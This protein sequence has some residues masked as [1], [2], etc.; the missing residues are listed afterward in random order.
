M[1]SSSVLT[2]LLTATAVVPFL[3]VSASP[4]AA[5][6]RS[7][8]L[9]TNVVESQFD[10]LNVGDVIAIR[11]SQ[12]VRKWG[13]S[14]DDNATQFD[15]V[16][17]ERS[18]AAR[19]GTVRV[20][21]DQ[22]APVEIAK[23]ATKTK[24]KTT[25]ASSASKTASSSASRSSS[26]SSSSSSD[27]SKSSSSV[28]SKSSSSAV[29]KSSS[30][31]M[32]TSANATITST[33]L[34]SSKSSSSS[35]ASS[36][37]DTEA[38]PTESSSSSKVASVSKTASSS[39]NGT[40]ISTKASST[41]S[42]ISTTSRNSTSASTSASATDSSGSSEST[43]KPSSGASFKCLD[44]EVS[45]ETKPLGGSGV[46]YGA[47]KGDDEEKISMKT[48]KD[49]KGA[50]DNEWKLLQKIGDADNIL[51][52]Y[53]R[54][55][56][57]GSEYIMFDPVEGGTL[58]TRIDAQE[59]KG[60]NDA[61]RT[62]IN[63]VFSA[64]KKMHEK[65]VA[66]QNL[67]TEAIVFNEAGD[68]KVMGLDKSTDKKITDEI[69]VEGGIIAPEAE[70][71]STMEIDPFLNDSWEMAHL[72]ITMLIGKKAWVNAKDEAIKGVWF[73]GAPSQRASG[74]KKAWPEFTDDF[75]DIISQIMVDQNSRKP[76]SWFAEQVA[77]DGLKFVDE[78][79]KDSQK[80]STRRTVDEGELLVVGVE[81]AGDEWVVRAV[82]P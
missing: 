25:K 2:A 31:I 80:K 11:G 66:H 26:S 40:A 30:S 41:G 57:K 12:I 23:R 9:V 64:V 74:C 81:D 16:A 54:C 15:A 37:S 60:K 24:A 28:V 65:G 49:G 18:V 47:T 8:A 51:K 1:S 79:K 63:Q 76:V 3:G 48:L 33:K 42:A 52:G 56:G 35:V 20:S 29:S 70:N 7:P 45:V 43:P 21:S 71:K 36:S 32:S 58:K 69:K 78:C 38:E 13:V 27:V 59:Y 55:E 61:T 4:F 5:Q 75:C 46:L 77:N 68:V 17:I 44:S 6:A 53:G 39:V 50:L 82:L 34:S 22:Y 62:V 10:F 67:N 73:K 19:S 72:L 14:D